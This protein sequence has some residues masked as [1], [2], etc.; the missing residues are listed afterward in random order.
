MALNE[1][2][3]YYSHHNMW[4]QLKNQSSGL[5]S[6]CCIHTSFPDYEFKLF[7]N[8]EDPIL[9]ATQPNATSCMG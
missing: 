3:L 1:K 6:D 7:D 8:N 4:K 2:L 9:I 5:D